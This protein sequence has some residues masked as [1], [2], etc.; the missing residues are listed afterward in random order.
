MP[1]DT[2]NA[3]R[4]SIDPDLFF[5]KEKLSPKTMATGLSG[6]RMAS[7]NARGTI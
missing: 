4:S 6:K 2:Q 3:R 7:K 1:A 5:P